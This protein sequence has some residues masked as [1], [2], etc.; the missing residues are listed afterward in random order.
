MKNFILTITLA[1]LSITA[2]GQRSAREYFLVGNDFFNQGDVG[3]SIR[4]YN[5][6]IEMDS[7]K[8]DYFYARGVAKTYYDNLDALPDY[9]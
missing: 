2:F 3:F 7:T 8:A 9:N 4:A 1:I 6:A 5:R